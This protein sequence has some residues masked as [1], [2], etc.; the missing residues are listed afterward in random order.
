MNMFWQETENCDLSNDSNDNYWLILMLEKKNAKPT[1]Q[2]LNF[3][4][5]VNITD[6]LCTKQG[7]VGLKSAAYDQEWFQIKR[8]L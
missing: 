3:S 5:V 4:R 7:N 1:S 2:F 6:N 8:G